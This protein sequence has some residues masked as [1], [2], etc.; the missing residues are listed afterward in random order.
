MIHLKFKLLFV[1]SFCSMIVANSQEITVITYNIRLDAAVDGINQWGNRKDK[2]FQL[3]NEQAPDILGIQEGLP[4]QVKDLA[5]QFSNYFYVGVGREDGNDKGEYSAIFF[6]KKKFK[7]IT[8][9]TFWLSPTPTIAGSKGWDAAITR[10][11]TYAKVQY[12]PNKKELFVFNTHFDH[13]GET[14]RVESAKLILKIINEKVGTLPVILCGDF[15]SEPSNGAYKILA[16][17]KE[18]ELIESSTLNPIK[19]NCT[20]T[21]FAVNGGICKQ[22]DFI[23]YSKQFSLI[24]NKTITQNNGQYYPS[25]HL[26]VKAMLFL[27]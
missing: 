5:K 16:A 18:P 21:G 7:L 22:I 25:D 19:D 12:L 14:A 2:V 13:V 9:E 17:C 20:F 6:L 11:C 15:N 24:Q 4:N 3:I 27:N 26:P 1:L 10:I 23:F 8:S